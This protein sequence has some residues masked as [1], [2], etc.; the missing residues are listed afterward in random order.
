[1][2]I[3]VAIRAEHPELAEQGI[4]SLEVW[5][6]YNLHGD[7]VNVLWPR[8]EADLPEF[9]FCLLDVDSRELLAEG[10]TAPCWW[11]GTQGGLS[12]GIDT[13]MSEAFE[14]LDRGGPASA[15]CALAAEIP[16]RN[17]GLGLA[18]TILTAMRDIAAQHSLDHLIAPVRPSWKERYP[19]TP[20]ERYATWRREDGQL[21]DPW[22]RVHERLGATV[23]PPLPRS[24]RIS[25]TVGEW[26]EWTGLR[27][28]ET[29]DYVFPHGLA[30]VAID[31]EQNVGDYWEPNV[32]MIHAI[33]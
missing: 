7:V 15:L 23:G 12:D 32:W 27:F 14:R 18:T 9:Q 22:M 3:E 5:P 20:I 11:D 31:C 25:G 17:R 33:P 16:P 4:P 24:M 28:P 6:E 21:L 2:A 10:F 8:L 13:T 19:L 1:M 30:S 29:G 26:E